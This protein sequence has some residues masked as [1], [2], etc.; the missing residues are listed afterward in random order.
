MRNLVRYALVLTCLLG[1]TTG[2]AQA[3]NIQVFATAAGRTVSGEVYVDA[4]TPVAH[5]PVRVY[6]QDKLVN[7]LRADERGRFQFR[8]PCR[9]DLRIVA[10]TEDGH[11]AEWTVPAGELPES[12][13]R[14]E[15]AAE[16]PPSPS[17]AP[18]QDTSV[19]TSVDAQALQP[20]LEQA[21]A[22][23][24]APLRRELKAHQDR[25]RLRDIIG[26]IGYI[27]GI[28]GLTALVVARKRSRPPKE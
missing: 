20:L 19:H 8:A 17:E 26:G 1:V 10:T 16:T 5:A 9:A 3:H 24:V 15:G 25:A 11:R 14:C 7:E 23:Q 12:L 21:V 27:V 13:P 2:A 28:F 6:V 4:S 18:P 22:R